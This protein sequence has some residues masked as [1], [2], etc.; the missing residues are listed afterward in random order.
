MT[1]KVW[2]EMESGMAGS[3]LEDLEEDLRF[4]L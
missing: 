1:I 3:S 2:E 4:I